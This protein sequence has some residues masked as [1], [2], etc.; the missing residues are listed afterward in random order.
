MAESMTN[1]LGCNTLYPHGRLMN[2][3]KQFTLEAQIRAVQDLAE[4]GF[5]CVEYSHVEYLSMEDVERLRKATEEAKL[6][7]WSVHSWVGLP[8]EQSE[9]ERTMTALGPMVEK[10]RV[11]GAKVLVIHPGGHMLSHEGAS[12]HSRRL[13]GNLSVL[14]PL[15]ECTAK[16]GVSVAVENCG[17]LED[18][19]FI[20]ELVRLSGHKNVGF[21]IDT[22]HAKLYGVSPAEAILK[23]GKRLLT[24]HLQDNL[25]RRDDHLAPGLGLIDWSA[26]FAA[27][28]QIGYTRTLMVEISDCPPGREPEPQKELAI[29]YA[30]VKKFMATAHEISQ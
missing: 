24:T 1:P 14:R 8:A 20:L 6:T 2:I 16:I 18:L 15:C 5:E 9:A 4:A 22:G 21:C 23:M 10:C 29:A 17:P 26:V 30:N 11:L 13:S 7:P 12:A 27:L 28:H 25:G 3:E 19:E